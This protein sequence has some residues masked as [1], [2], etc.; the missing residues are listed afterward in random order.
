MEKCMRELEYCK[1]YADGAIKPTTLD[2]KID[3]LN[4]GH[5]YKKMNSDSFRLTLHGYPDENHSHLV[6]YLEREDDSDTSGA[7]RILKFKD[8]QQL[9]LAMIMKGD[10]EK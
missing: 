4:D 1:K 3:F 8:G 7:L 2:I 10:A 9:Q 5:I 6:D